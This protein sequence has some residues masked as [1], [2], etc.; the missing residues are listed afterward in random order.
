MQHQVSTLQLE[1]LKSKHYEIALPVFIYL[2]FYAYT[3]IWS[4]CNNV[5]VQVLFQCVK[6]FCICYDLQLSFLQL[7]LYYDCCSLL[8]VS[9]SLVLL[10]LYVVS[11]LM[12]LRR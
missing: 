2:F 5:L 11:R 9:L 4:V 6:T 12:A 8:P 3:Y 1:I 10:L 7:K